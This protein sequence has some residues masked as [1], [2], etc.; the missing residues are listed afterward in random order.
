YSSLILRQVISKISFQSQ[1]LAPSFSLKLLVSGRRIL[2][3]F[4]PLSTASF[5]ASDQPDRTPSG[6][7]T[8]S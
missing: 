7:I 4:K 8:T 1:P 6:S 3:R 5:A 2:Q